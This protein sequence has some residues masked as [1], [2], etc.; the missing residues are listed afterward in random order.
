MAPN[1]AQLFLALNN[2]FNCNLLIRVLYS[3][4]VSPASV[5]GIYDNHKSISHPCGLSFIQSVF[6]VSIISYNLIALSNAFEA[7][8]TQLLFHSV[9]E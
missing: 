3:A 2:S 9:L 5:N 1:D 6:H 8:S 4:L 7:C